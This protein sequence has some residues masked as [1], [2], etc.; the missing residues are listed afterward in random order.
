MIH[1]LSD[2]SVPC[3]LRLSAVT[4][5]A[6]Y[7][8]MT[9]G[10]GPNKYKPLPT[11]AIEWLQRFPASIN[12]HATTEDQDTGTSEVCNILCLFVSRWDDCSNEI[13]YHVTCSRER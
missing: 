2:T 11:N 13:T 1:I 5:E 3:N 6:Q 12:R 9:S 10:N 7:A 8:N 4:I